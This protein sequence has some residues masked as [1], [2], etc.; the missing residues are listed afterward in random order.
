MKAFR[1]QRN[2][3][4]LVKE[5]FF[6]KQFNNGEKTFQSEKK[7]YNAFKTLSAL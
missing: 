5:T 4:G 6:E 2:V 1:I 7:K 3:S